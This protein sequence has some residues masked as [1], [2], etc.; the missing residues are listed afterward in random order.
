MS[1]SAQ[2]AAMFAEVEREMGGLDILVNN[3]GIAETSP[4]ERE[5][6]VKIGE[7]RMGELLSGEGVRTHWDVTE[8]MTDEAW[9]RMLAVHLNGT[10]FCTRE[11]LRIMSRQN[12]AGAIVNLSSVAAW[13]LE[14]VPHYSAAKG[15]IL[16]FTRAVAREVGSRG[17][18]VN[19]ICPGYIDTPMTAPISP[20][21]RATIT[22]RTPLGRTGDPREVAMT[23]LF[24]ASD[25][26]A[27][28]TGQWLS[29]NGGLMIG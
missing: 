7:A 18:R 13:G 3:A 8:R 4:G 6:L 10:F 15:G 25:D 17:I 1:D 5:R 14:T 27:F 21:A 9:T 26:G 16:A 19:A 28:Y 12:R 24:L 2:V 23:A 20:L 22:A 11:A 29:P